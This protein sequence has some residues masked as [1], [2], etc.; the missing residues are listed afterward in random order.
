MVCPVM[1][2]QSLGPQLTNLP[3]EELYRPWSWSLSSIVNIVVVVLLMFFGWKMLKKGRGG[4][5]AKRIVPLRIE[6]KESGNSE[7]KK[8]LIIGG[9]SIGGSALVS[10]LAEEGTVSIDCLDLFIPADK[11]KFTFVSRYI[12][13]DPKNKE[14][15][16]IA[17][18]DVETVYVMPTLTIPDEDER[19]PE[20][21]IPISEEAVMNIVDCCSSI[22]AVS[23]LVVVTNASD[24]ARAVNDGG[25]VTEMSCPDGSSEVEE[26][27]L[28]ADGEELKTCVVRSAIVYTSLGD[29]SDIDIETH[30][31]CGNRDPK[32]RFPLVSGRHLA[33]VV[34][35]AKNQSSEGE[36]GRLYI[37]YE[38]T[39]SGKE[40]EDLYLSNMQSS[41]RLK[42]LQ[43]LMVSG[44]RKARIQFEI[45]DSETRQLLKL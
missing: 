25:K 26:T 35:R 17:L 3:F 8:V 34:L 41:L 40:Y 38:K 23:H 9:S 39:A 6:D 42:D 5:E 36:S 44:K 22:E 24:T 4:K 16:M 11:W 15:L 20:H 31:L 13:C 27:V 30:E 10:R 33:E 29:T 21:Y 12:Q 43:Q 28:D 19:S 45:D 14:D 18:R 32:W 37:A 2:R 7:S 1:Q